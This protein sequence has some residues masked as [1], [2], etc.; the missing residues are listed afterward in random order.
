MQLLV[1]FTAGLLRSVVEG[2]NSCSR[3]VWFMGF[4]YEHEAGTDISHVCV[5][6][7]PLH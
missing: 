5:N 7:L 6:L 4:V 2:V 1:F 3:F